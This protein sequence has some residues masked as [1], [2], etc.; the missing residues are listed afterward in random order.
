[1]TRARTPKSARNT[2]RRARRGGTTL[3]E[4]LMALLVM[5]IGLTSVISLFPLSML[6][7]VEATKL[8]NATLARIN[9]EA[10]IKASVWV[11]TFG[12]PIRQAIVEDPD[13]DG[14]V[15]EHDATKFVFDPLGWVTMVGDGVPP[16]TA[17]HFGDFDGDSA[18][19]AASPIYRYNFFSATELG[20]PLVDP[21]PANPDLTKLARAQVTL[22]DSFV[23]VADLLGG[24]ISVSGATLTVTNGPSLAEYSSGQ[25]VRV[26]F[27]HADGRQS[28]VRDDDVASVT[29]AGTI[30]IGTPLPASYAGN[31][32][33]V[34]IESRERRYTWIATVRRYGPKPSVTVAVFF[35]RTFSPEDEKVF[36]VNEPAGSYN[37]FEMASAD[38]DGDGS[39]DRPPGMRVGGYMFDVN[40]FR[41]LKIASITDVKSA[42]PPFIRFTTDPEDIDPLIQPRVGFQAMFPRNVVEAYTLKKD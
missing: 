6:R 38:A 39:L 18:I 29:G 30:D 28:V 3:T 1:M 23:T 21:N 20:L 42:T 15:R 36:T 31:V 40:T 33:R 22:P 5:G 10:R 37:E 26:T 9:A 17:S 14:N 7:S 12:N 27:L 24:A 11:D 41:W 19:D 4:V 32:G 25:P 2:T 16:A 8:T 34:V 13:K 35:R